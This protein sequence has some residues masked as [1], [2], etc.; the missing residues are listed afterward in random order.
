MSETYRNSPEKKFSPEHE[1][2]I[3]T[4]RQLL[5]LPKTVEGGPYYSHRPT[6][7][8]EKAQRLLGRV[9][10]GNPNPSGSI[11]NFFEIP[12]SE[13]RS[14]II[15]LKGLGGWG[16]GLY[17]KQVIAKDLDTGRTTESLTMYTNQVR[18]DKPAAT[19]YGAWYEK[20]TWSQELLEPIDDVNEISKLHAELVEAFERLRAET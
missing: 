5:Q 20:I 9:V 12:K 13:T 14:K 15:G 6:T 19:D 7:R 2:L 8:K 3:L 17:L 4:A 18:N 1:R 16:D 11:G 10:G